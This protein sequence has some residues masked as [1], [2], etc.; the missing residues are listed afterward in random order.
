MS[1]TLHGFFNG[2]LTLVQADEHHGTAI[3]D[4]IGL[5]FKVSSRYLEHTLTRDDVIKD[6]H[7][8]KVAKRLRELARGKLREQVFDELDAA[9]RAG[10]PEPGS[11]ELE[12]LLVLYNAALWHLRDA[13]RLSRALGKRACARA[14]SGR[15]WTWGELAKAG[16]K[17]LYF[18]SGATALSEAVEAQGRAVIA[19]FAGV[20][21]PAPASPQAPLRPSKTHSPDRETPRRSLRPLDQALM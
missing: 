14:P 16:G 10:Y 5:S 17:G 4:L 3:E 21:E 19:S 18:A 9:V 1:R 11:A 15:V 7:F 2:G 8:G 12:R 20:V 13:R 6:G